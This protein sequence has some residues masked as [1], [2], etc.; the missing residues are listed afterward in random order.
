MSPLDE[1]KVKVEPI[2]DIEDMM[3]ID[4]M[5]M[6]RVKSEQEYC[7]EHNEVN[8][9]ETQLDSF[10]LP[11]DIWDIKCEQDMDMAM[12]ETIETIDDND[13]NNDNSECHTNVNSNTRRRKQIINL[14]TTND[15]NS[16][17]KISYILNKVRDRRVKEKF[18]V[19]RGSLGCQK[20]FPNPILRQLH[21]DT[22]HA[23]KKSFEKPILRQLH[24]DTDHVTKSDKNKNINDIR[25]SLMSRIGL[26][27]SRPDKYRCTVEDCDYRSQTN[28]D[29]QIHSASHL[30]SG[31]KCDWKGC[32]AVLKTRFKLSEHKRRH[33][34]QKKQ[35]I[36]PFVCDSLGCG[37]GFETSNGLVCHKET[38]H[39]EFQCTSGQC[40]AVLSNKTQFVQHLDTHSDQTFRCDSDGCE[41]VFD[42]R[43]AL[44]DHTKY[45]I[46]SLLVANTFGPV[47]AIGPCEKAYAVRE[48][49]AFKS[50]QRHCFICL[51]YKQ[52]R[53]SVTFGCSQCK[54]PFC[55]D[56]NTIELTCFQRHIIHNL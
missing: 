34:N 46:G 9:D 11:N 2:D 40:N 33:E 38:N 28:N 41:S 39:S 52:I 56:S 10:I 13:H 42:T 53:R 29:L 8:T 36:Y 23:K 21:E 26:S 48:K 12:S 27:T 4:N 30:L 20:S 31:F 18:T 25:E 32:H 19:C 15:T 54:R 49:G 43:Q 1:T 35:V 37:Q 51:R 44:E 6:V 24:E 16:D 5:N 3:N 45:H 50:K 17:L 22:V 47:K 55:N 14:K 7:Q